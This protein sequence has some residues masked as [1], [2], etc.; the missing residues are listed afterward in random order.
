[1]LEK[2][3]YGMNRMSITEEGFLSSELNAF[4]DSLIEKYSDTFTICRR[5]NVYSQKLLFELEIHNQLFDELIIGAAYKRLLSSYQGTLILAESGMTN[6]MK[7]L[8]RN[9]LEHVFLINAVSKNKNIA[10]RFLKNDEIQRRKMLNK[11]MNLNNNPEKE[12][13]DT[14]VRNVLNEIKEK[15]DKEHIEELKPWQIAKE[16]GLS[17]HYDTYYT[18]LSMAVHP[19]AREFQNDYNASKSN[20]IMSIN[21]GPNET[22]IEKVL[23]SNA[24]YLLIVI[25][26]V[27]YLFRIKTDEE[28]LKLK[29]DYS[30]IWKARV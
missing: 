20:S 25:E 22:D 9:M 6:E 3:L 2:I 24:G 16:A 10:K 1:M 21:F 30:E 27:K 7:V 5:I 11:Y 19:T 12:K 23:L 13:N 26:Q 18:I 15:I 28:L 4:K 8:S 17:D 29:K 14:S